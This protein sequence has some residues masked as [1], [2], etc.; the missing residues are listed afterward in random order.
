M[1]EPEFKLFL[2]TV[3]MNTRKTHGMLKPVT[4]L[5]AAIPAV[6]AILFA[7]ALLGQDEIPFQAASPY[8]RLD[9]EYTRHQ[10]QLLSRGVSEN[11]VS[12][13]SELLLLREDGSV[14]Y[15]MITAHDAKPIK[16]SVGPDG[17]NRLKALIKETG[18]S[19]INAKFPISKNTTEYTVSTIK[20]NLNGERSEIRWPEQNATDMFIPPV[21]TAVQEELDNIIRMAP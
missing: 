17:V 21:I 19:S 13:Y 11:T 12:V 14:E 3:L 15:T 5:A 10:V 16:Y 8:D 1:F 7:I 4:I 20:V 18:F 9:I 6:I 2:T